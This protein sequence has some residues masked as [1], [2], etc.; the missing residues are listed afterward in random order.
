MT[1]DEPRLTSD[2]ELQAIR[3]G[4]VTPHNAPITLV[5][6]DQRWPALYAREADRIRSILGAQAMLIE[7]VGSTS[8]PGLAAKP[9]I[10]IVLA[11]PDSA[12]DAGYLSALEAAGYRLHIREPDWYEHRLLKGPDTDVNVHVFSAGCAEIGRM[13]AFRDRLRVSDADR[14]A[15]QRVKRELAG[16]TWRHTQHYA[17]AKTAIVAEIMARASAG[18]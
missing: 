14:A 7:H 11:V 15:Y 10:D 4:P 6:Y 3:A 9:I 16:R 1:G 12:D 18:G 17:D 13:L 5:D 2:E 8:V